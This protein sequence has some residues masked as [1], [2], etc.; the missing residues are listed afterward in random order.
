MLLT[1]LGLFTGQTNV[2]KTLPP[3][4]KGMECACTD[5]D[6]SRC[7]AGVGCFTVLK[8][9]DEKTGYIVKKGC[10]KNEIHH[11]TT[12]DNP[13][14]PVYCCGENMCNWNVTPP[15]PTTQPGTRVA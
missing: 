15:F 12:C 3:P 14:H 13:H 8:P 4:H 1:A 9:D 2:T 7:K 6:W 5:C 11:S 10:I